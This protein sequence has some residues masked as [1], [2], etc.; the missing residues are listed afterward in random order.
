MVRTPNE[1]CGGRGDGT[2]GDPMSREEWLTAYSKYSKFMSIVR[3]T[4]A[5]S[6]T[7]IDSP[8]VK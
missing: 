7:H 5:A 6:I 3:I 8:Y 2:C 4:H 1:T